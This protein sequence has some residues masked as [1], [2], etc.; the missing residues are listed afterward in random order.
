[1]PY[2]IKFTD[3]DKPELTVFDN[4]S[5]TDTS[6]IFPGRNVTGYG[7][8]IAENFLHLLENFASVN[9]PVSPV[10][11][12]LWYDSASGSLQISDGLNWKA[13]S[14]IRKG[15]I[16]PSLDESKEGELW[17]DTANQQLR[18]Y[19][20]FRWI[21]VGPNQTSIDG[22]K[23]GPSVETIDDT[24]NKKRSIVVFYISDVPVA[25]ISKDS[26]TPKLNIPGFINIRSGVNINGSR[27]DEKGL[28]SNLT[29]TAAIADA[30]KVSESQPPIPASRFLRSDAINT[31]D[32]GFNIRNASGL[33]VGVDGNFNISTTST[34]ARIYNSTQ[35]GSIDL[36][37]NR[38]G[39]PDSILTVKDN[40][41]GINNTSPNQELDIIGNATMTGI[42]SITN[43][44]ETTSINN[45][46]FRTTGGAAIAKSL[47][48]GSNLK[49]G[50]TSHV[51]DLQPETNNLYDIGHTNYRWNT[52]WTKKLVAEEIQGIL[53]GN[54]DG[55]AK[56]ATNLTNT[57]TFQIIGDVRST[58][59][60]FDGQSG[61]FNKIFV[62]ELT[63]NI[64]AGKPEIE[65]SS[66]EDQILVY[67]PS[68][69]V[70]I[71]STDFVI[72]QITPTYECITNIPHTLVVGD[73]FSP[74]VSSN[75]FT[76]G[77][78]YYV[79]EV[80][81]SNR[82]K[83][84]V[85]DGGAVLP[86]TP[87]T[88]LNIPGSKG[89][90]TSGLVKENRDTFVGD[91][92]VPVG[93]ML[94]YAGTT[95]PYGYLFC[96][97]SEVEQAKYPALFV[98]IGSIYNGTTPLSGIGTF[99]LPDLRGRF[100]LGRNNMD[101]GLQVPLVTGGFVDAGGGDA[102]DPL[103]SSK[104]RV[105]DANSLAQPGGQSTR[106]LTLSNLPD[107]SHDLTVNNIPYGAV[108]V[109]PVRTP[110][111]NSGFGPTAS[112]QAQY[113]NE[114]GSVKKPSLGFELGVP[115]N[116]MNP[117]LTLNYIIRSGPPAFTTIITT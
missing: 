33:T 37:I 46:S 25:I 6:L 90:F 39:V 54:I 110:P 81:S 93:S 18:I 62:S 107:H 20:G 78:P 111:A 86:L 47:Q 8:I 21:L 16:E 10:E 116:V 97:G 44:A 57:T 35:N 108:R 36:Q 23:F 31:T 27:I 60:S 55:N 99:R 102:K 92:G 61:G 34:G 106:A 9:S 38:N 52:V 101:N 72:L 65:Q 43:T 70:S 49:V 29:G 24:D 12:Q 50:G 85:F 89:N 58:G 80:S 28:Q 1:M 113:I 5:N 3:E 115:V 117:Y 100:A 11:G 22:L 53:I 48:V 64:I 26:F 67:R 79:V 112:G 114:T 4:T 56:T 19:N 45:G 66:R 96:D 71:T 13:A 42:L 17:I 77:A 91:L 7:Q 94:P 14:G 15:P 82:F 104:P 105:A 87:G 83:V 98:A 88:S 2:N 30:L 59:V 73:T 41:I 63:S 69:A 68:L 32:F 109:D 75:G 84:S 103:D 74:N 95:A 76:G 51:R 40:K